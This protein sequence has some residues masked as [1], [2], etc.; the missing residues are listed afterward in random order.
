M[1][2]SPVV[3]VRNAVEEVAVAVDVAVVAALSKGMDGE[4]SSSRSLASRRRR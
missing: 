4:D 3:V 1:V 2:S